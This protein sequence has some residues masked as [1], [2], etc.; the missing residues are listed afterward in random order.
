[1]NIKNEEAKLVFLRY[2]LPSMVGKAG[3][4]GSCSGMPINF[5]ESQISEFV[6]Q[7]SEDKVPELDIGKTFRVANAMCTLIATK[8][9]KSEIDEEVIREYFLF[10]HNGFVIRRSE[11]GE[12]FDHIACKTYA[13]KIIR[14]NDGLAL[15]HTSAGEKEYLT[16]FLKNAKVGESVAVHFDYIAERISSETVKKMGDPSAYGRKLKVG[17]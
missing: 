14:V 13:G 7:V 12:K 6:K 9:E 8:M 17:G 15:V 1:V 3:G 10:E 11:E 16:S 5:T 2:A 4:L